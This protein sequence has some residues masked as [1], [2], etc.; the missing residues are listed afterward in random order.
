MDKQATIQELIDQARNTRNLI[1][2]VAAAY[3]DTTVDKV[4]IVID[5]EKICEKKYKRN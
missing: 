5:N 3:F 4:K 2:E 1:H